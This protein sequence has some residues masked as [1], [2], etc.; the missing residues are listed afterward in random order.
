[1]GAQLQSQS[2]PP[3]LCSAVCSFARQL[4]SNEHGTMQVMAIRSGTAILNNF[5]T[6]QIYSYI[7]DSSKF[8]IMYTYETV[9][10]AVN[11]LS[12]RGYNDNLS[13]QADYLYCDSKDLQL[14]PKEF[15]IDEVY[16]FEGITDPGDES[17][18]YAISSNDGKV[19]GT[20]VNA[21]GPYFDSASE[22]LVDKLSIKH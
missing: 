15:Q 19:K 8:E 18:V 10:E 16:R 17:I 6:R 1:M 13:V 9:T 5:F 12:K 22:E 14:S 20:L 7:Y 2:R 4:S 21:Y 3:E 11:D